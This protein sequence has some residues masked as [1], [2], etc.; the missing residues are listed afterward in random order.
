MTNENV[1]IINIGEKTIYLLGTAHV[2]SESA[3]E[4]YELIREIKPDSVCIELDADRL[5]SIKNQDRWNDTDIISVIKQ[6]KSAFLLANIILSAYQKRLADKFGISAGQEMIESIRAADE[7]GANIITVDRSLRTTFLRIW[8]KLRLWD[9]MKLLY[10]V[11]FSFADD[12]E[13]TQQ[14][15]E[16]LKTQD[17]LESALSELG[18]S[19]PSLKKYLVDERDIFLSQSIKN[20]PGN[21]IVA[22]VGAAH[23]PGIRKLIYEDLDITEINSVPPPSKAAKAAGWLLPA[24]ILVMIVLTFTYDSVSGINQVMRWIL[25]NGTLSA[26]GALIAG[27]HPIAILTAFA[28]APVTSLNPLL[29]AGWFAGL[30]EAY[31]LKPKVSDFEQLG[32]DLS[33]LKGLWKNKLTR[34]LL[35]VILSNLGSV[36]GTY[37]GGIEIFVIFKNIFMR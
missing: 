13:V 23:T 6:K 28:A 11:L 12:E 17:M 4:A 26:L 32:N 19:F 36:A 34:I 1:S 35:V 33:S 30:V 21:T 22:V 15:I 10:A 25:Y 7:T 2:S 8:R 18:D 16:K 14:D 5:Q 29:A 37:L 20:A 31:I 24:I 3:D 27:G 9:K